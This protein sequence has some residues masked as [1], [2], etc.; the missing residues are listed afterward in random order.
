MQAGRDIGTNVLIG[1]KLHSLVLLQAH[2]TTF[3]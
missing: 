3:V 1:P 2:K